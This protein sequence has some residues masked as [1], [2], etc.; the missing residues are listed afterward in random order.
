MQ[1]RNMRRPSY[2]LQ[3]FVCSPHFWLCVLGVPFAVAVFRSLIERIYC[4]SREV[5]LN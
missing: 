4:T 2:I 1:V 3:L 5:K